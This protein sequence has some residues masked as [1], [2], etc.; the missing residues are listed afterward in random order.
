VCCVEEWA[1]QKPML[2]RLGWLTA[3]AGHLVRGVEGVYVLCEGKV[4]LASGSPGPRS[5]WLIFLSVE[6]WA[7]GLALLRV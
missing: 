4:F 7:A 6:A 1:V 3:R 5:S 2:Y